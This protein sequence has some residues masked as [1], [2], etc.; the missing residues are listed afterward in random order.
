MSNINV[1]EGSGKTVATETI[2][3]ADYQK[4]KLFDGS[5]GSTYGAVIDSGG[6][7]LVRVVNPTSTS[8]TV[9]VSVLGTVP[10]TQSGTWRTSVISA[11]PSS[12]LVGASILGQLPAGTAVL[13]SI[14]TLQGTNPWIITGSVQ[15]AVSGSVFAVPTGNQSVS[16]DVGSSIIGIAINNQADGNTALL[17]LNV[18]GYNRVFNGSNWDR[19]RGNSSVGTLVSTAASSVITINLAGSIMA[20]SATSPAGSILSI[21]NPAGSVTGVRTDNASVITTQI[22]GSIMSVSATQ[23]A[24]SVLAIITPTGSVQAVR[25]DNA[26]VIAISTNVGSVITVNQ[27]SSIIAVVTGSVA[28]VFQGSVLTIP[29]SSTI[30][31]WKDS[32]VLAV[33]VGSTITVWKDSS[34]LSVPVGSVI[35]VFQAASIVGTYAEDAAHTSGDKGILALNVR[36]D[37]LASITS[38]DGDYGAIALGPSGE[39][40]TANAPLTKWIRG[41]SSLLTAAGGSIVAIAAP[42]ASIFTYITGIQFA[43]F[44]SQSVLLTIGGGLGSTL[45]QYV[46]P[47][48]GSQIVGYLP[49]ALKTGENSAITTSIGGSGAITSSVYVGIQ[50]FTSKS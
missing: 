2:G 47:A 45:G 37:T 46:V 42:G 29:T 31:V 44:G 11:T 22:A 35:T 25:T 6:A 19:V 13:G 17:Q 10:V 32:S 20:V 14:M 7:Q 33:P 12:M 28:T 5:T 1:T 24:G 27:S 9:N 38:A 23:P 21:T 48:G 40:I 36:N 39:V 8:G 15:A 3:G 43:G 41:T 16:G 50:G 26:S 4:I 34:I 30:T 49:N 18:A